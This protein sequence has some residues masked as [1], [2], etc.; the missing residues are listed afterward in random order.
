MAGKPVMYMPYT[1]PRAPSGE[2]LTFEEIA[3]RSNGN[4]KL[5][6]FKSDID[7][8]GLVFSSSL[9]EQM[10]FS[11]Y[12]DLSYQLHYFFSAYYA[13]FVR[14]HNYSQNGKSIP[15]SDVIYTVFSGGDDLCI[16]GAWDAVLHFASDFEAELRKFTNNNPSLTLS[17]GIVLSSCGVPVRNIAANAEE[18]LETSKGRMENGKTVKN[19]VTVFETTLSWSE[20]KQCLENERKLESL[21]QDGTLS[22]GVVYNL[23]DF[24][25]RAEKVKQGDVSELLK[26]N[27]TPHDRIWKSNFKYI[28]TRNI[29]KDEQ[30]DLYNWFLQFGSSQDEMIKA[31]VAASY[32]LYTQRNK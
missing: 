7:N 12:A 26:A 31:R 9:G 30:K 18:N 15:Y 32:A 13:W 22:M 11:R 25:A 1:A 17:G 28:A 19:A 6:M 4:N 16:L 5:A 8:L 24:A 21:L 3:L 14:T 10:S 29:N 23:I 27:T 20:Y 2:I